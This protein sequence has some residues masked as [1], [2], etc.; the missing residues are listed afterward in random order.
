[1]QLKIKKLKSQSW[2]RKLVKHFCKLETEEKFKVIIRGNEKLFLE[3]W[4]WCRAVLL[5]RKVSQNAIDHQL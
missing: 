4:G 3:A 5:M 1:M 2:I